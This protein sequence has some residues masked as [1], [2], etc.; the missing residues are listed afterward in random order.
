MLNITGKYVTVFN[1]HVNE[2]TSTRSVYATLSTSKKNVIN[3]VVSYE[4]MS[5][6]GKFVAGAFDKAKGLKD[7]D[8]I[9]IKKGSITNK[10]DKENKRLY[11]DVTI[12]DF[13]M[14]EIK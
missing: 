13:D 2:E 8:K 1:P 14:S 7:F 9:D 10:Y 4:N 5:W 6:S 3:G 12:F 11:V